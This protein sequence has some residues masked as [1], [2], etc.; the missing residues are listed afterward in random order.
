MI[1][2]PNVSC[3]EWPGGGYYKD[4]RDNKLHEFDGS[5]IKMDSFVFKITFPNFDVNKPD[6][7]DGFEIIDLKLYVER[8]N[9]KN[10]TEPELKETDIKVQYKYS[11]IRKNIDPMKINHIHIHEKRNDLCFIYK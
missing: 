3:K 9:P 8:K 7:P 6:R 5:E 4:S 11:R 1:G 10:A 2:G